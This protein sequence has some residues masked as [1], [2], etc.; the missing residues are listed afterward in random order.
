MEHL[1]GK[2]V[3]RYYKLTLTVVDPDDV[4]K[5]KEYY[6]KTYLDGIFLDKELTQP[7][8]ESLIPNHLRPEEKELF[9]KSAL[10]GGLVLLDQN[11]F[12]PLEYFDKTTQALIIEFDNVTD[13]LQ[14]N[15]FTDKYKSRLVMVRDGRDDPLDIVESID[16][17]YWTIY[18]F[19]GG[20]SHQRENWQKVTREIEM[21][22]VANWEDIIGKPR[23]DILEIQEM[24]RVRH[25]H[26][27]MNV[28]NELEEADDGLLTYKGIKLTPR[29]T[30]HAITVT[31]DPYVGTMP[32][33]LVFHVTE[34]RMSGETDEEEALILEGNCDGFFS[35][36]LDLE[37][38]PLLNTVNV[39][40]MRN[41][42]SKCLLLKTTPWY[43]TS[44]VK[45]TSHMYFKCNRLESIATMD[46]SEVENTDYMFAYCTSL[47]RLQSLGLG[48]KLKSAIGM[49]INCTNI[50]FIGDMSTSELEN[51]TDMFSGCEKLK[52]IPSMY[53]RNI[54]DA[55][56]MFKGCKL[57]ENLMILD[58]GLTENM[59]EMFADC[60]NLKSIYQIDFSSAVN[61]LNIFSG[62][63]N[64]E[65]IDIVK[66]SLKR[67]ISFAYTKLSTTSLVKIIYNLPIIEERENIVITGT[68]ACD[69]SQTLIDNANEKG[70]NIII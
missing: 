13:L 19:L 33:D 54:K 50:E 26:A 68:P 1:T 61:L 4:T 56:R 36:R 51:A 70:W 44:K 37:E 63:S 17:P 60:Y 66:G 53:F 11:G 9:I 45:N 5:T 14:R 8:Y 30:F 6:P 47:I 69:I 39:T 10:E 64:L 48:D 2:E 12:V 58:T 46:F 42:F 62:C 28:I 22:I 49:F 20:D 16:R 67:S 43:N 38:G 27:N 21:D 35:N 59:T 24:A 32:G 57:L 41:F 15:D 3:N 29:E 7:F 65:S 34:S 55:T 23:S 31:K 52:E 18:R 40:S 25:D